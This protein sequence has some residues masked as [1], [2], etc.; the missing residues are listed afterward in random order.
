MSL[1]RYFNKS[2]RFKANRFEEWQAGRCISKGEIDTQILA[3][4]NGSVLSFTLEYTRE[5]RI[6]R[7]FEFDKM[8][9]R[10]L[11]DKIQYVRSSDFNPKEPVVCHL[12]VKDD[13]LRCV[14]FAMTNPD[15]LIEFYGGEISAADSFNNLLFKM[16]GW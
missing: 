15:R 9:S 14:R 2:F 11:R 5:L 8:N 13:G 10:I 16:L 6:T 7:S 4:D 1:E 3:V 12:F